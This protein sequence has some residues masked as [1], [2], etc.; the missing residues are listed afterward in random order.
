MSHIL[1]VDFPG[2]WVL[3]VFI[4]GPVDRPAQVTKG[5]MTAMTERAERRISMSQGTESPG[6][7]LFFFNYYYF[8]FTAVRPQAVEV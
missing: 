7:G 8:Y 5:R 2:I 1:W 6:A 3:T 4:S